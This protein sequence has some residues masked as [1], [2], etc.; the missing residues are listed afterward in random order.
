MFLW[1]DDKITVA[2]DSGSG[3]HILKEEADFNGVL[4]PISDARQ[5][6]AVS[7]ARPIAASI[8][9]YDSRAAS[10]LSG[11]SQAFEGRSCTTLKGAGM[12]RRR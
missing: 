8:T 5:S 9:V 4:L 6:N 2:I 3:H 1:Y 7:R 10:A 12:I 11:Q